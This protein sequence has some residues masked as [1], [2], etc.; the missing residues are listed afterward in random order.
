MEIIMGDTITAVA[1]SLGTV[2]QGTNTTF[3]LRITDFDGNPQDADSITITIED[4]HA[5]LI[6][7]SIPDKV[8]EGYY[9]YEWIIETTQTIGPYGITWTYTIDGDTRYEFQQVVVAYDDISEDPL[10]YSQYISAAR[11]I[12]EYYISCAQSIPVYREQSKPSI[13]Q[14]TFRFTFPRWNQVTGVKIYRN[15]RLVT[16]G[17]E[18]NYFNG[19]ISFDNTLLTEELVQADYNFRWFKDDE[20]NMFILN[21]LRMF[22]TFPPH[23]A[24]G[25]GMLPTRYLPGVIYK[26]AS[27]AIRKLM[28]CLQFQEPQQVFGGAE[29]SQK[30]FSNMETLKKNYEGDWKLIF[31]NKKLGPYAGLTQAVVVPEFT[32]PGGRCISFASKHLCS[33]NGTYSEVQTMDIYAAFMDG[34]RVDILSQS[35]KY[36]HLLF[37]PVSMI[38]KTGRKRAFELILSSGNEL[39]SSEDHLFYVDGKYKALQDVR[40]GDIMLVQ[41]GDCPE[42]S[43]VKN[44]RDLGYKEDMFDME[45]NS[46]ANLFA[47]GIKCHNSRWFRYLFSTN[48]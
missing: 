30:A 13:N 35:D 29:G 14:Q 20:L 42:K 44:I 41:D 40:V 26:A 32:L 39:V 47:N 48:S 2:K 6:V 46:T 31:E 27:D 5:S 18:V 7:S 21:A 43:I 24:Y 10:I 17:V 4:E 12:L 37:A 19:T 16:S 9:A 3:M 1:D 36:G 11:D 38:W 22:N 45:V 28:M 8:A 25:I 34:C 15:N 33:I 23:S